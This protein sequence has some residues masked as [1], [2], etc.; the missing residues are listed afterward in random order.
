MRI[1]A[2][3]LFGIT[4]IKLVTIDTWDLPTIYKVI[5]FILLGAILL[6]VAFLYQK[7][8]TL[9]FGDDDQIQA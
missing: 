9:I 6:I 3:S 2:I 4:L 7:F 1:S 8:K 5:A